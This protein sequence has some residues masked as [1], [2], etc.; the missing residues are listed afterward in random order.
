MT[1]MTHHRRPMHPEDPSDLVHCQP[2][3]MRFD[4]FHA[5]RARPVKM[6]QNVNGIEIHYV[7]NTITG[8]VDD[9]KFAGGP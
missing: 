1:K 3:H 8:A 4:E 7:R 2:R 9:F 5:V 6:A